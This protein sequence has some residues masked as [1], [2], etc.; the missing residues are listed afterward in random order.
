MASILRCPIFLTKTQN[1]EHH[2]NELESFLIFPSRYYEVI[3]FILTWT[4]PFSS[5]EITEA[6]FWAWIA[7]ETFAGDA[8]LN[9]KYITQN[10]STL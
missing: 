6:L 3:C 10:Y 2:L 4:S 8:C 7:E 5:P 1:E 9:S